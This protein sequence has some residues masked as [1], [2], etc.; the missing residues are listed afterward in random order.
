MNSQRSNSTKTLKKKT[1]AQAFDPATWWQAD[2]FPRRGFDE[3]GLRLLGR[4]CHV[5]H[6]VFAN[7]WWLRAL[8][9]A[10]ARQGTTSQKRTYKHLGVCRSL[11]VRY[12][13]DY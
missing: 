6:I 7:N 4:I 11:K 13:L 9:E 12:D 5:Q 3:G 1:S 10:M 8:S 2:P